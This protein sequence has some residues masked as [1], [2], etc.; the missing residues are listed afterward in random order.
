MTGE[1]AGRGRGGRFERTVDT[2]K[3]DA[4]AAR[5]K[6]KGLSYSQ[7]A[8]VME[9]ANSGGAYKAVARALA[10][11]PTE[12]VNEL[13]TVAVERLDEALRQVFGVI[14]RRH[15]LVQHGKVVL[16]P[17]TGEVMRDDAPLLAAVGL[18]LKIEERRSR[19]LGLDAPARVDMAVS[20]ETNRTIEAILT[21]MRAEVEAEVRRELL[22]GAVPGE[23]V[24]VAE[25][26]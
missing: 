11:V 25:E 10:A 19:L 6:A 18:L 16:D 8:E 9:Y 5:L 14:S 7:I 17:R 13:R 15:V 20:D 26:A 22:S 3:R 2:A 12:S 23:V 4:E 24:A 1:I 21:E